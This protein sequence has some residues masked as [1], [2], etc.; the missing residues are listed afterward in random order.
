[1]RNHSI[2]G[3]NEYY[4]AIASM[5]IAE[6]FLRGRIATMAETSRSRRMRLFV[7]KGPH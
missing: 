2:F 7:I 3:A 5:G 4:R 6:F 1:M